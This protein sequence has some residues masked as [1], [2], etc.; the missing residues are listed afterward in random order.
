MSAE[1]SPYSLRGKKVWVAGHRGMVG[2][3]LLRRL[4]DEDCEVLTV[5]REAVDLTRQGEVEQW[6]GKTRPQAIFISAAKVGGILANDTHPVPFLYDNLAIAA[7]VIHAA[8]AN[9]VEKLLYLGSSCIY[10]KFAPQ[11]IAESAL[12]TG[13]LEPTNQWYAIAKIA[14]LK[15]CQAYRRQF[16]CDFISAMPTNLYGPGDNFDI[17]SGHVIP[18]LMRKAHEARQAGQRE[19]VIWGSGTPRREFLHVD[20]AA[21]ALVRLMTHYSDEPQVNVGSGSDI[22]IFEL[23]K[24]IA[25]VAGFTGAVVP[26]TSKPDGTLR[27]LLD[28]SRLRSL[29]WRPRIGLADGLSRTYAWFVEALA[30]EQKPVGAL[31]RIR[32]LG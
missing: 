26:D 18:G 20:D 19:L 29:G 5:E 16:G 9:R 12:L 27:K 25:D 8:A 22:S 24:L 10:P 2:S 32:G 31:Q 17:E 30:D 3:A 6:M 15:L 1:A 14:G 7:N 11:P 23:A 4:A 28:S 21:D 13:A